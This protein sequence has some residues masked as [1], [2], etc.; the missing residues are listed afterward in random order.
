MASKPEK[1]SNGYRTRWYHG[2]Q[3]QGFTTLYEA[4][5][6]L[7]KRFIDSMGN[8]IP[9][10]DPLLMEGAYL[11]AG[12]LP[13]GAMKR[14]AVRTFAMAME[15]YLATKSWAPTTLKKFTQRYETHYQSWSDVDISTFT[16]EHLN[17]KY[18]QLV[19][20][21]LK[22]N[23]VVNYLEP[24]LQVFSYAYDMGWLAVNPVRS[25]HL[26]FSRTMERSETR[27]ALT[28][29]ELRAVLELSPDL[30][31]YDIINTMAQCGLRIGEVC[32]LAVEDVDLVKQII[33]VRATMVKSTRQL[34][35]KGNRRRPPRIIAINE[36][37]ALV[38]AGYVHDQPG[39]AP[40]FP[41][42]VEKKFRNPDRWRERVWTPMRHEAEEKRLVRHGVDLVPHILRHSMATFYSE[43]IPIRLVGQ[44][45]GHSTEKTTNGYV[46]RNLVLERDVMDRVYRAPGRER[47]LAAVD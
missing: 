47:L 22:Y 2:G 43:H 35:S 17:H 25:R 11:T 41:S 33:T 12:A 6:W 31:T 46:H 36:A 5:C 20:L 37:F 23:T 18:R 7:A 4:D 19:A 1:V 38:L 45:L 14:V 29:E 21:G 8:A 24:A 32:A 27:D 26:A 30:A 3:R 16:H 15:S 28:Y 40:L 34:W 10:D 9:Q 42:R 44:R 13:D 39:S